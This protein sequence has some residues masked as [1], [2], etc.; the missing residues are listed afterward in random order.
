VIEIGDSERVWWSGDQEIRRGKEKLLH[1]KGM[2]SA[3]FREYFYLRAGQ[4]MSLYLAASG[5]R[6]KPRGFPGALAGRW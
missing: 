5:V 4:S 1:G 6:E 2:V 3:P